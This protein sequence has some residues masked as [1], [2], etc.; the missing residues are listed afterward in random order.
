MDRL[1]AQNAREEG[2][3]RQTLRESD[4]LLGVYDEYRIG[5]LRYRTDPA[6]R[7]LNYT[8][9]FAVPPWSTLRE[10]EYASLEIERNSAERNKDYLKWLRMLIAP[11]GSLGGARPKAGVVDAQ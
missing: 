9:E 1:E 5:A 6:G 3:T 4:Y 11:G 7:F 10:L 2:R 8:R